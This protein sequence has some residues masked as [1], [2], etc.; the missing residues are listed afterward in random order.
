MFDAKMTRATQGNRN[1]TVPWYLMAAWAYYQD[2]SPILSDAAFDSLCGVLKT[3]WMQ[4]WHWHKPLIDYRELAA[5]TCFLAADKYPL[6]VI[7]AVQQLRTNGS[8]KCP[9]G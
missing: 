9:D 3:Q 2:D 1:L 4:I 8:T 7:G 6:R 5:G